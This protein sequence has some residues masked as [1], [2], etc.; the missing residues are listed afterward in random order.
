M[1]RKKDLLT[2]A[3]RELAELRNIGREMLDDSIEDMR[4][5]ADSFGQFCSANTLARIT[6]KLENLQAF[7]DAMIVDLRNKGISATDLAVVAKVSRQ[8]I[9]Q[10]LEKKAR[11][12][13][14]VR[15]IASK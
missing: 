9:Y 11:P 4:G 1:A 2:K 3:N 12:P 6:Q 10:I 8:R 15:R 13:S 14:S 7:R 5:A